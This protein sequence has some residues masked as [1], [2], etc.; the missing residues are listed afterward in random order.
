MSHG[1]PFSECVALCDEAPQVAAV[2][3]NCTPP[4]HI[5]KLLD[6]AAVATNKPLAVYPNSGEG[7]DAIRHEWIPAEASFSIVDHASEWRELGARL[8]GGCCRTTPETIR[9]IREALG[10]N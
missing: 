3:V 9:E 10:R 1:E 7:W 6:S 8:I 5:S 2:G 4:Q